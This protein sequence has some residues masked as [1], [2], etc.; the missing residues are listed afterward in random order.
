MMIL[1]MNAQAHKPKKRRSLPLFL[2]ILFVMSYICWAI[3][4][5]KIKAHTS[6]VYKSRPAAVSL[7]WPAYGQAAVGAVSYGVLDSHGAQVPV[8]MASI[9]KVI[10]AL[11][12]IKQKPLAPG[13]QGP[14]IAITSEDV[15]TYKDY[16][17]KGGSVV[18]VT[19]GEQLSEAQAL[20]AMLLPSANNMAD[21]LAR[22]AFGSMDKY[23]SFANS[24]VK[25]LGL[26]GTHLDD[27]SGFSPKST[28]TAQDL[29]SL[30]LLF[31]NDQ[32]LRDI[33]SQATAEIPVAGT[34]HNTNWLLGNN[35]VVGI[36]TGNTEQAG[37]CYL[38]A[39]KR[40]VDGHN[41]TLIGA[42]M[43]APD[44]ASAIG[45][46]QSLLQSVEGGFFNVTVVRRDQ[47]V[48]YYEA[49]WGGIANILSRDDVSMLTWK[50]R[51]VVSS[52]KIADNKDS[53]AKNQEIGELTATVWDKKSTSK[54]IVSNDIAAPTWQWR[55][56]RRHF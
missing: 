22:W 20:Q 52:V 36:K 38:V 55:L 13:N 42:I 3:P 49:P 31:E 54:L 29:A 23:V 39:A 12:V 11:A 15:A 43:G 48:G 7:T 18:S 51:Q 46:S 44:L 2:L 19:E 34:V 1:K 28:S 33:S 40:V 17:A 32:V 45:D 27:A 5:P 41:L 50:T 30:G 14:T 6:Y 4:L 53:V 24:Y 35:G 10:T 25:Q 37:G 21:T 16:Y 47:V 9:T 8:P 56:Y 26:S